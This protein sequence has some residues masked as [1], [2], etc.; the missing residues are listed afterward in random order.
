MYP[1]REPSAQ[2]LPHPPRALLAARPAAHRTHPRT[3]V[4][5]AHDTEAYNPAMPILECPGGYTSDFATED[6]PPCTQSRLAHAHDDGRAPCHGQRGL[7][8]ALAQAA[9]LSAPDRLVDPANPAAKT[10]FLAMEALRGMGG[11][12][13][14]RG[15]QRFVNEVERCHVATATLHAAGVPALCAL[16]R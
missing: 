6:R 1:N 15:S 3:I 7:A 2:R 8:A 5:G 13:D 4:Q 14:A 16:C 10:K 12:L 9:G 11:L